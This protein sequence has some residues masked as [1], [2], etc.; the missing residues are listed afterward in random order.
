LIA[1]LF[2]RFP[3][4]AGLLVMSMINNISGGAEKPCTM[5]DQTSTFMGLRP[6]KLAALGR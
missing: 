2:A 6:M 5:P 4:T 1:R 3:I